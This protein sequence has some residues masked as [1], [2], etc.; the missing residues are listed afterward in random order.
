[1]NL[2]RPENVSLIIISLFFLGACGAVP[3]GSV[4]SGSGNN[5]PVAASVSDFNHVV[6]QLHGAHNEWEG[7]PYLLG[8]SG[9]NGVDCSSFIQI[10]FKEFFSRDLPRNTRAQLQEGSGVRRN[11][12]RPGDLIFFRT[13][14][15]VLHVGIAMEEGDFLHASVSNGVMISNLSQRYWAG[16]YLGSRRVL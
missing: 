14:R 2:L 15:G 1:M 11:Q 13:N 12:I 4:S 8:G 3:R 7:T 6:Q 9:I 16:R 5:S 10:V